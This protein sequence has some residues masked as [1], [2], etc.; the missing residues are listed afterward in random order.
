[1]IDSVTHEPE[2]DDDTRQVRVVADRSR[3]DDHVVET[4][5]AQVAELRDA[6][7]ALGKETR[8]SSVKL[9]MRLETAIVSAAEAKEAVHSTQLQVKQVQKLKD[10][11]EVV[12]QTLDSSD[13]ANLFSFALERALTTPGVGE[14]MGAPFHT[15]REI[16]A[17]TLLVTMQTIY[18]YSFE[19]SSRVIQIHSQ[20]PPYRPPVSPAFFYPRT[21]IEGAEGA[22]IAVPRVNVAAAACSLILLAISTK[23]DNEGTLLTVCPLDVLVFPS[24]Y[25]LHWRRMSPLSRLR[26][27]LL[28]IHMQLLWTVRVTLLPVL[29]TLGSAA[30]FAASYSPQDVVLNSVAIAFVFVSSAP[31]LRDKA[32]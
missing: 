15:F 21:S 29:A 4:L 6:M 20:L 16:F 30:A 25:G 3:A 9:D 24:L 5:M 18:C 8:K 19:D 23:N 27:L 7:E 2:A 10:E 26:W 17:I 14:V 32:R 13:L 12:P 11:Q 31:H 1:M 28:V 22:D